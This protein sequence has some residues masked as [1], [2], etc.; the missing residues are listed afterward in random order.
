VIWPNIYRPILQVVNTFGLVLLNLNSVPYAVIFLYGHKKKKKKERGKP[1]PLNSLV[2]SD[3]RSACEREIY[4]NCCCY[5]RQ[6]WK[7]MANN[8]GYP[9]FR[10]FLS[11]RQYILT[12]ALFTISAFVFS[13][14]LLLYGFAP[15]ED[16]I[17]KDDT[18]LEEPQQS[19]SVQQQVL[20]RFSYLNFEKC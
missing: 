7:K 2:H 5:S 3:F 6:S 12:T 20:L 13:I 18:R 10:R 17:L 15:K 14:F 19:Q 4:L 11:R 1:S 8:R 16:D 9:H